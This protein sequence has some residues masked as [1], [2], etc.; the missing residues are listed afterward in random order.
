MTHPT[1]NDRIVLIQS[2]LNV[3]IKYETVGR[4][5]DYENWPYSCKRTRRH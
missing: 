1:I 4:E 2:E 3:A 5:R